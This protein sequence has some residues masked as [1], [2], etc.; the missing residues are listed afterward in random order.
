MS[1]DNSKIHPF[2]NKIET[3]LR[4]LTILNASF[5]TSFDLQTLVYLDYLT[6]HSGDIVDGIK[7]LHTPV[8]SRKGE[9]FVRRNIIF[10]G[11]ELFE[12]KGLISKKYESKGIEYSASE[13]ATPFIECLSEEYFL[14]LNSK[15]KWVVN[16]FTNISI[17]DLE[18]YM[19]NYM[20]IGD[21]N[22]SVNLIS[23]E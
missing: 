19:Q 17:H 3:G 13:N 9:L 8:P 21:N 12:V 2:N 1:K 4:I 5:P 20:S 14:E 22:Y 23:N 15:A 6:V 11:L 7:S 18:K 16:K 10:E